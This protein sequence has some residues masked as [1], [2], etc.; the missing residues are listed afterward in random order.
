MFLGGFPLKRLMPSY[1]KYSPIGGQISLSSGV[2]GVL[3]VVNGGTN[4]STALVNDLA[5]GSVAGAIKEFSNLKLKPNGDVAAGT[6]AIA[7]NAVAGFMYIPANSGAPA[8]TPTGVGGFVPLYFNTATGDLYVYNGSW[9]KVN[10]A[11]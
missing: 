6:S 5:M 1:A 4:S 8:G 9:I 3:P 2:S 7:T 11:P 10:L